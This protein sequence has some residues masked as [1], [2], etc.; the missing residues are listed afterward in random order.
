MN[1][2]NI[3]SVW[4]DMIKLRWIL[5]IWIFYSYPSWSL[6]TF[7]QQAQ[8][9]CSACHLNFGELTPVGRKFKL[10]GYA[11]GN[12]VN[13]L[14]VNGT[15]SLTK[16]SNTDSSIDPSVS[17]PKNGKVLPEELNVFMAGKLT[18]QIGGNVKI[19]VNAINTTPL[20]STSGVQTGTRVG[21]DVFLDNSEI[22]FAQSA[23]MNSV[24][25]VWGLTLNNAPS[26][27]DLW[28]TT[29]G[30]GF[31]YRTSSLLNAWGLGQFGPTAMMDNGM[32]SQV[33]GV[34]M[35]AM[36][37]DVWYGEFTSYHGS[38]TTIPAL[39]VATANNA[40]STSNNPYWRLAWN[41]V[42]GPHSW[43]IGTFGMV[44]RL[45]RDRLVTGSSSGKY[46]D[47]GLDA[48]YQFITP[49]HSWSAQVSLIQEKV[50]WSA[51]AVG[52]NHDAQ[53]TTLN[54]LKAKLTYDFARTYGAT[55]FG[56]SSNGS[57]DS[58]YWAYNSNPS[59]TTG[60]CNQN[61]SLL[62]YC[63]SNGMPN[64]AG[65]GFEFYYS[66]IPQLR[67]NLQQTYYRSFLGGRTFIDN[68]S[69]NS[70]SASDNNL[71]YLYATYSY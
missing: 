52:T 39:E 38:K 15:V 53:T 45:S 18:E 51:R 62:A 2:K 68:T 58:L 54:N 24:P 6:P 29:P 65:Q 56:F 42:E 66:P 27:Q 13:P 37:N 33:L 5:L 41:P 12:R 64:T 44:S 11:R 7:S 28:S 47:I 55:W 50:D 8:M 16:I 19:T 31:P 40:V 49:S 1:L 48:Q 4:F 30:H 69:G 14:S 32:N 10:M 20:F 26:T 61:S 57:T 22:R 17:L 35:F 43:M 34:G 3:N 67:I 25:L 9:A 70:R 23:Q 59:V 46:T 21:K 36:L 71:T 63:S 60:A